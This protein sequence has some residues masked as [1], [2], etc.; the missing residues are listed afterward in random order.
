MSL[1]GSTRQQR[2]RMQNTDCLKMA[3][4]SQLVTPAT[5]TAPALTLISHT[6]ESPTVPRGR[7]HFAVRNEE[8][9]I[10]LSELAPRET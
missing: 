3:N 1:Y 6:P 8:G 2:L 4:R 10:S 5:V 7:L 9:G